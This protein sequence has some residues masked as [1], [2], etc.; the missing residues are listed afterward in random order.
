M[1]LLHLSSVLT[2]T[3]FVSALGYSFHTRHALSCFETW[4]RRKMANSGWNDFVKNEGVLPR[5]KGERSV[6]HIIKRW[7]P[8]WIG[9][10]LFRNGLL[11]H[12]IE[13]HIEGKRRQ[14]RRRK[15][16][17]DDLKEGRRHWNSKDGAMD[18]IQWGA[19]Y[20]T[21]DVPVAGQAVKRSDL[22]KGLWYKA[23]KSGISV[24]LHTPDFYR[25]NNETVVAVL[26][27]CPQLQQQGQTHTQ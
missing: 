22:H 17:L 16:L 11:K 1:I 5:I 14:G 4:W 18:G 21:G 6:L 3:I 26:Y 20:R 13:G 23:A 10:I 27:L 24:P 7:N 8:N 15:Q 9:H 25:S 19:R 2:K 12:I